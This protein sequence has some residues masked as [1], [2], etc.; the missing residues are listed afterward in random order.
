[1]LGVRVLAL[2]SAL[3]HLDLSPHG[4]QSP[5][6][7]M[8]PQ[9]DRNTDLSQENCASMGYSAK[10]QEGKEKRPHKYMAGPLHRGL[11]AAGTFKE[12]KDLKKAGQSRT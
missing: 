2:C 5:H 4:G 10:T 12:V 1:M 3:C 6:D 9:S 11:K 7:H 8:W